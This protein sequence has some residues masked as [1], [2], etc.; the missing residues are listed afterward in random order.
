MTEQQLN[1]FREKFAKVIEKHK[2]EITVIREDVVK[3]LLEIKDEL[4]LDDKSN[5]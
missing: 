2:D 4:T 5:E 3:T 1:K